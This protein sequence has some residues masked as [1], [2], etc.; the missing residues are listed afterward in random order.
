MS[1]IRPSLAL[2]LQLGPCPLRVSNGPSVFA[3]ETRLTDD[4]VHGLLREV[5]LDES[6]TVAHED[7]RIELP[8]VPY[9]PP[10][11]TGR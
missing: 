6:D 7:D 4:R 5:T 2:S 10:K 3:S 1:S 11:D 8:A 9:R